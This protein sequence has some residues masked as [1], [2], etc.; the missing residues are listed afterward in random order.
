M[1][2][3]TTTSLTETETT[4]R[5]TSGK[6]RATLRELQAL[7]MIGPYLLLN[8]RRET[9]RDRYLDTPGNRLRKA[10]YALRIRQAGEAVRITLKG[11]ST[12]NDDGSR[13][14]LEIELPFTSGNTARLFRE[15]ESRGITLRGDWNCAAPT[16]REDVLNGARLASFQERTMFRDTRDV[17]AQDADSGPIAE[18]VIDQVVYRPGG[19]ECRHAEMEIELKPGCDPA[20]LGSAARL[21]LD[22]FRDRLVLWWHGKLTIGLALEQLFRDGPQPGLMDD[23]SWLTEEAYRRIREALR[24]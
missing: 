15:L 21:F 2:E 3:P 24:R 22:R 14:R 18:M 13:S 9:V 8:P 5:L 12:R 10:R 6:R 11:P 4:L 17:V 23:H 7:E 20:H 1:D 16:S 19:L